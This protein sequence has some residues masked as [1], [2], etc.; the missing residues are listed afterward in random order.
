[1]FLFCSFLTIIFVL[2]W[3]MLQI[4]NKKKNRR[5]KYEIRDN[6]ML[7]LDKTVQQQT[8]RSLKYDVPI[9]YKKKRYT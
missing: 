4:K 8:K 7:N 6:D 9:K 1:M 3:N 2:L 5:T